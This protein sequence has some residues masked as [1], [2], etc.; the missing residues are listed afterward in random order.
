[1][2]YTLNSKPDSRGDEHLYVADFNARL[3][4]IEAY[5]RQHGGDYEH[6]YQ[7]VTGKPW[8]AGRSVKVKN[9]VGEMTAD[10][11]FKSVL[12]KYV[13]APA[14]VAATAAFAPAVLPA[15]G[16]TVAGV[17]TGIGHTLGIGGAATGA[18]GAAGGTGAAT[19]GGL[20]A[21]LKPVLQYGLPAATT[22]I[23]QHMAN[24]AE[25]RAAETQA[26]YLN[27]ALAVEQ[28]KQQYERA[29]RVDYLA[30]LQ[31]FYRA[32]VDATNRASTL[33]QTGWNPAARS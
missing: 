16:H 6:A 5:K 29:Q 12:G 20:S 31:P 18:G 32:G 15:I 26:D 14:A 24:S 30:R 8:P 3:P 11:T 25:E 2:A 19:A 22:L 17:G 33:L 28:E 23:G 10:R 9:G 4:A 7:A 27:R 21:W 13:A 1:M